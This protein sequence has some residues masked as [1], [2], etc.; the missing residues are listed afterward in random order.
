M[1]SLLLA[2]NQRCDKSAIA[3]EWQCAVKLIAMNITWRNVGKHKANVTPYF[4]WGWIV[5]W[6]GVLKAKM[7]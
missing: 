2:I 4:L 5:R 7:A 3:G 1:W 6:V